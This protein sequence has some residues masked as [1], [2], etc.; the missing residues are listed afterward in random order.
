MIMEAGRQ[1]FVGTWIWAILLADD[2]S[3]G[4]NSS[5]VWDLVA[6]GEE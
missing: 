5:L 6:A 1:D 4:L 2:T 3:Q